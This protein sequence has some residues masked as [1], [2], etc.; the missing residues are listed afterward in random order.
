MRSD[1]ISIMALGSML[2][3]VGSDKSEEDIS[4]TILT[5]LL[6]FAPL[7]LKNEYLK[8][9]SETFSFYFQ[10]ISYDEIIE[11]VQKSNKSE[12]DRPFEY[13]NLEKFQESTAATSISKRNRVSIVSHN[14][15]HEELAHHIDT[16]ELI[17]EYI[18]IME[19]RINAE[20]KNNNSMSNSVV[21]AEIAN[22]NRF[23]YSGADWTLNLLPTLL[24]IKI[25]F[26]AGSINKIL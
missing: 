24:I 23:F 14:D 5:S 21:D 10:N 18:R 19:E 2:V 1:W 3:V 15:I 7:L 20:S 8:K 9:L 11:R 4:K 25:A 6:N 26:I 17:S 22:I 13:L 16:D 12:R